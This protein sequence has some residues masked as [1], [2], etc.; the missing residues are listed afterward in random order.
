ML[1]RTCNSPQ[2]LNV[3]WEH[4]PHLEPRHLRSFIRLFLGNLVRNCPPHLHPGLL[5][6]TLPQVLGLLRTRLD[7]GYQNLQG[8][9]GNEVGDIASDHVVRLLHREVV[10]LLMSLVDGGQGLAAQAAALA[11]I[12]GM[13]RPDLSCI[14]KASVVCAPLS[15]ALG[16]CDY[17]RSCIRSCES[18]R[19][20][21]VRGKRSCWRRGGRRW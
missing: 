13:E 17:N 20:A 9:S 3:L 11:S 21:V 14:A 15:H 10:E 16:L 8:S 12:Q 2:M 18:R 4:L 1:T 5:Q 19:Q 6:G 7:E